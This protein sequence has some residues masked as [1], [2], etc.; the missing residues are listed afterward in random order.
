M[1]QKE[2][3]LNTVIRWHDDL[4][5][6]KAKMSILIGVDLISEEGDLMCDWIKANRI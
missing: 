4:R 5:K 6:K 3:A 1:C 2:V